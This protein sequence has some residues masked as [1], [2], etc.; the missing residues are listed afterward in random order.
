MEHETLDSEA[1][2]FSTCIDD[3]Y[4]SRWAVACWLKHAMQEEC[5]L[6]Q[7]LGCRGTTREKAW[8]RL[9]GLLRSSVRADDC[10]Q[11]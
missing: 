5:V 10:C 11:K 4:E 2:T 3:T 1:E 6:M 9:I 7:R 8:E